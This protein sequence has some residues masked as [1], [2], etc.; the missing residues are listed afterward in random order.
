M[1]KIEKKKEHSQ[2]RVPNP[3]KIFF[4]NEGKVKTFFG[5]RKLREVVT[6]SYKQ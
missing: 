3:A 2:P 6:N 5:E 1:W 4:R